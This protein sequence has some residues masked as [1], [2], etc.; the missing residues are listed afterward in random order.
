MKK[1]KLKMCIPVLLLAS[2]L[3]GCE[4]ENDCLICGTPKNQTPSIPRNRPPLAASV[5]L[6]VA[7][8]ESISGVVQ[9]NDPE[10]DPITF[11]IETGP[12]RGDLQL[13]GR[14]AYTYTAPGAFS[15]ED[16]FELR[17]S[18]NQRNT[19]FA[20]V[21]VQISG[22]AASGT[23]A[24]TT[25]SLGA[26]PQKITVHPR[27]PSR[28]AVLTR[29]GS[30]YTGI[31]TSRDGGATWL[32]S[33]ALRELD[34]MKL[35]F[36]PTRH[37]LL[38][39]A[40]EG[41]DQAGIKRSSDHGVTWQTRLG[42]LSATDVTAV[43]PSNAVRTT[44]WAAT[45]KGLHVSEDD[46][47]SWEGREI[48]RQFV[49]VT[50]HRV[51][52]RKAYAS[53]LSGLFLTSDE[54]NIDIDE[55]GAY[56]QLSSTGQELYAFRDDALTRRYISSGGYGETTHLLGSGAGTPV[57]LADFAVD[58]NES[59]NLYAIESDRLIVSR[60]AGAI[61][62]LV[63]EADALGILTSV[64]VSNEG[65]VYLGTADGIACLRL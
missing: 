57:A 47:Q 61:W 36:H 11:K 41:F 49:S 34:V 42:N 29:D 25:T 7:A 14:G 13:T 64:A 38:F 26:R 54:G 33:D 16:V 9:A 59:E 28:I 8:G 65:T 22:G 6:S 44:V 50:A 15:G 45:E 43:V 46:G 3:V 10:N 5:L 17:V 19:S 55:D 1:I 21:T 12:A 48:S 30:N 40:V 37:G 4:V 20:S 24:V 58:P 63:D 60:D 62:S 56:S 53:T 23:C 39:A 52:P 32:V 35:V 51:S 27:D 31:H 18:D 2:I